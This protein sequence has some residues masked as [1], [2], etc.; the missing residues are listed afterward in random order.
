MI[1]QAKSLDVIPYILEAASKIKGF[2][3]DPEDLS[4]YMVA[5]IHR[6]SMLVLFEVAKGG[7]LNGVLVAEIVTNMMVKEVA[8]N[9][10]Y[11]DP[12]QNGLGKQHRVG[13]RGL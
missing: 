9:L 11:V 10:C 12:S 13:L 7:N 5:N 6:L 8:I 3:Y 4:L 1:I 2:E